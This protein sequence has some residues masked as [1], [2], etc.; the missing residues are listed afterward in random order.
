MSICNRIKLVVFLAALFPSAVHGD[1]PSKNSKIGIAEFVRSVH[2]EGVPFDEASR[3]GPAAVPALVSMLSNKKETAHWNNIVVTLGMIGDARVVDTLIA[4]VGSGGPEVV[5]DGVY[6]A[7]TNTLL[8]LGYI[9]NKSG[10]KKALAYLVESLDPVVWRDR[11]GLKWVS[12]LQNAR[13]RDVHLATMAVIA[14][15]CLAIRTP[16]MCCI[17]SSPQMYSAGSRGR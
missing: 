4:F 17:T 16:A 7:K 8:A 2:V 14:W 9:V 5:S 11:R 15:P 3:H 6:K 10:D 12:P 1:P 13:D